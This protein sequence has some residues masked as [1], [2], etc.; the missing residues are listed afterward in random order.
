MGEEADCWEPPQSCLIPLSDTISQKTRD[1]LAQRTH[2]IYDEKNH[3]WILG[4]TR[5]V[6][7][8]M[9][10]DL[11]KKGTIDDYVIADITVMKHCISADIWFT[12]NNSTQDTTMTCVAHADENDTIESAFDRAMDGI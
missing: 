10:F 9:Y 12:H 3:V 8:K 2:K 4:I 5:K 1:I 7:N 6:L 11:K